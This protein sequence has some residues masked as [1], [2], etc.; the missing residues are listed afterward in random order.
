MGR[1]TFLE[2]AELVGRD[3]NEVHA[4]LTALI[5]AGVVEHEAAGVRFPYEAIDVNYKSAAASEPAKSLPGTEVFSSED[6]NGT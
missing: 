5:K 4:D 1:V 2:A 6:G 3:V